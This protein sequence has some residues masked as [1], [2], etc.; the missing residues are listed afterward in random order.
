MADVI[1]KLLN[2]AGLNDFFQIDGS[3]WMEVDED[4]ELYNPSPSNDLGGEDSFHNV[5]TPEMKEA[6]NKAISDAYNQ[7]SEEAWREL[8]E[9]R[10]KGNP[11]SKSVTFNSITFSSQNQAARYA[12]KEFGVSRNTAIRYIQEGRDINDRKRKNMTYSGT[13]TGAKYE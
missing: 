11:Q 6:R 3:D 13:Y 7:M 10:V 12:M 9:H 4:Y 2:V 5:A 1:M 8:I